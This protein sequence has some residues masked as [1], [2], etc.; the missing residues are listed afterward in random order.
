MYILD[1][2]G[3]RAAGSAYHLFAFCPLLQNQTPHPPPHFGPGGGG[4]EGGNLIFLQF[5][6][7]DFGEGI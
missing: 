1:Q 7:V 3:L 2:N 4:G 5:S 6:T